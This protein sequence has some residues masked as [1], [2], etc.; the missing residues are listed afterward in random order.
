[1]KFKIQFSPFRALAIAA[2]PTLIV[3]SLGATVVSE[4]DSMQAISIVLTASGLVWIIL[5][6]WCIIENITIVQEEQNDD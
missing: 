2:I 5:V 3:Y 4:Q 1:M 6:V